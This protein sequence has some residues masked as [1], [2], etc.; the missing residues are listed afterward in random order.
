M[1]TPEGTTPINE[2]TD[3]IDEL[4]DDVLAEDDE[5]LEIDEIDDE[6]EEA[7]SPTPVEEEL[8][9]EEEEEEDD[10]GEKKNPTFTLLGKEYDWD[11]VIVGL[12]II[13][14]WILI[15]RTSGLAKTLKYDRV[16]GVIFILFIAYVLLNTYTAGN[17]S[18]GV[19]YEL[20]ILLTVEQMVSILFGTIVLF[21]IFEKNIP[22]HDN[23][24]TIIRRLSMSIVVILTTASLW[25]NVFTS[26]RAFR[27]VR[28]FKQGVYNVALTL[29]I[30][31]GLI[32][33]KGNKCP[34][35][36]MN[37]LPM[38]NPKI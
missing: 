10:I 21:A 15:W 31:V 35:V 5:E 9:E 25:V 12:L 32:F 8:E 24:R 37:K 17:S 33:L 16:F 23:C 18:G 29:F 34:K 19:V 20:N 22:V 3:F 4:A 6:P 30:L 1:S 14:I 26:G 7:V 11:S 2:L 13:V 27:A 28:K 38:G 36:K